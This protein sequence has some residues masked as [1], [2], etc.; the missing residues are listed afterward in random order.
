M[1]D[2][3]FTDEAPDSYKEK[4][5]LDFVNPNSLEI[6]T[7][8]VEPSLATAQNEDKFQFQR[9]GYFT[10]DKDSTPSKL[11]FN[12]TVGLKDAW[13]EKGK[14]EENS[15]NNSLKD[16]NKY[17]KVETKPE[18]IAIESAIGENIKNIS[19][20]SL[21]QN[22][23]KKNINNNKASLLF[24]QFILKYSNWK[25]TD[26]EEE[27]IKKLYSMS[28]KSESTYVRSKAL[29]NLRDIES[30]S[31]KNQFDDEILKL[32]SNPP[33]NASEREIEI[34]SEMVKK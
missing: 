18:R 1:Y 20:F 30:E 7:G 12:K 4:N 13:E 3:L 9:L 31:F 32:Y 11:V 26:F 2:R 29:L 34:L 14:K 28:L 19:T 21:L 17:F 33:K 27:D 10:V 16:I 22:S 15:I 23:L 25:S 6:V 24:S 8:Y 5:F